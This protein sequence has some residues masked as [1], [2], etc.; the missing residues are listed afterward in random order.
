[1]ALNAVLRL[2]LGA[3]VVAAE[4]PRAVVAKVE[5]P[6][7]VPSAGELV[8]D[9]DAKIAKMERELASMRS[10]R[11][12]DAKRETASSGR[13]GT[14]ARHAPAVPAA[15]HALPTGVPSVIASATQAKRQSAP[16]SADGHPM[17]ATRTA[18]KPPAGDRESDGLVH[19]DHPRQRAQIREMGTEIIKYR[20]DAGDAA[21]KPEVHEDEGDDDF[22][23][24]MKALQS[25]ADARKRRSDAEE[26]RPKLVVVKPQA[27]PSKAFLRVEPPVTAEKAERDFEEVSGHLHDADAAVGE[28]RVSDSTEDP[29]SPPAVRD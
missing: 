19:S 5:G 21:L 2:L 25:A 11:Q 22:A 15:V 18:V 4:M 13:S 9:D 16:D 7:Q 6:K 12:Q 8:K 20:Y 28:L 14:S 3:A 29:V 23:D 26:S 1:M 24:A 27:K 17:L 10:Q